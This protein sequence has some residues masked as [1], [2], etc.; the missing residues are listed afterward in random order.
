[1]ANVGSTDRMLRFALGA[2]LLAAPFLPPLA[3]F[4]EGLGLWKFA[5]V[6]VGAILVA[7]AALRFCPAYRLIGISTRRI[8]A[9]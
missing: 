6:A 2:V 9:P 7:T 3:G 4:F 5:I 1:M 8:P